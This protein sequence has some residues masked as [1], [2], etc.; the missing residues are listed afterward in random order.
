MPF[1]CPE[2]KRL[3]SEM[4]D[5]K[6]RECAELEEKQKSYFAKLKFIADCCAKLVP[7]T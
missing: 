3:K 2:C 4:K 5:K 6:C 7:A 1:E